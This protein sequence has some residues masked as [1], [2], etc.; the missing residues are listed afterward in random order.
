MRIRVVSEEQLSKTM[1]V[2]L[3]RSD[4]ETYTLADDFVMMAIKFLEEERRLD[5][6]MLFEVAVLKEPKSAKAYNNLGFCLLPDDPVRALECF[7]KA[8]ELEGADIQLVSVNRILV[9]ALLGRRA[10]AIDL[11]Q[12]FLDS[13]SATEHVFA[14]L[15]DYDS[16]LCEGT[17]ELISCQ[18]Y[19]GYVRGLIETIKML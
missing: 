1:A 11:A 7:E 18:D 10:S 9:L 16:I 5:A 6:V 12:S 8:L 3:A 19:A 17:T 14:W 4:Q 2:R 13:D 15:W